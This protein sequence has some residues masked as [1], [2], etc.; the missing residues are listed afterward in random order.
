MWDGRFV[1]T[2]SGVETAI[3]S[4]S[5]SLGF[6]SSSIGEEEDKGLRSPSR[7]MVSANR[8]RNLDFGAV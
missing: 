8:R 3:I 7:V 1:T 5:S 2:N 4:T 6:S